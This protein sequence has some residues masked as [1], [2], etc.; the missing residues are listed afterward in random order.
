MRGA[1]SMVAGLG[2]P[3]NIVAVEACGLRV[4][5]EVRDPLMVDEDTL[6]GPGVLAVVRSDAVVQIV[7]GPG[8]GELADRMA[9]VIAVAQ[10]TGGVSVRPGSEP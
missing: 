9:R 8:A 10:D 6:R 1:A 7:T 5:V 3:D 4:R 2:G